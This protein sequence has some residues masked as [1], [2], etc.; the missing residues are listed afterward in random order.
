M[1]QR[2]HLPPDGQVA[3]HARAQHRF[4]RFIIPDYKPRRGSDYGPVR[5]E[6]RVTR[7][8][9]DMY[10]KLYHRWFIFRQRPF[11]VTQSPYT[12]NET[13]EE[14]LAELDH[15]TR[16]LR[17]EVPWQQEQLEYFHVKRI[18]DG[19]TLYAS[20]PRSKHNN[21]APPFKAPPP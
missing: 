15:Q 1:N 21:S 11:P 3:T 14:N 6:T 17:S 5:P 9:E 12:F 13:K 19:L 4:D 20:Q 8:E 16:S 2:L 10:N 7:V 18:D